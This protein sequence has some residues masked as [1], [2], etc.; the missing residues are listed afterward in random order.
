MTNSHS[1]PQL[2]Q[3]KQVLLA[4]LTEEQK[5]IAFLDFVNNVDISKCNNLLKD[6]AVSFEDFSN[7]LS[8]L[9]SAPTNLLLECYNKNNNN[10]NNNNNNS[11]SNSNSNNNSHRNKL[12]NIDIINILQNKVLQTKKRNSNSNKIHK[13]K[14]SHKYKFPQQTNERYIENYK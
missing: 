13:S 9:R 7:S 10:N 11:N 14:K 12:N 3:N 8:I 5:R 4:E 2:S 1:K 6:S